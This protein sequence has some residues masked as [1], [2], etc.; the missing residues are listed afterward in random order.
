MLREPNLNKCLAVIFI[1]TSLIIS[2]TFT[3]EPI[4]ASPHTI[5]VPDNYPTITDAIGNATDGTTIYVRQGT[6]Q[7]HTIEI[8]KTLTLIGE[9]PNTTIINNIDVTSWDG[10]SPFFPPPKIAIIIN[11]DNVNISGFTITCKY[12]SWPSIE[13]NANKTQITGNIMNQTDVININGNNNTFAQNTIIGKGNGY[14]TCTGSNNIITDNTITGR[15]SGNINIKGSSNIIYNNTIT[16]CNGYGSIDIAGNKNTVAKNNLTNSGHLGISGSNNIV[17]ANT[18]NSNLALVGSNNTFYANYAQGIIIGSTNADATNN[19]LYL[20]NFNFLDEA[21]PVGDKT[22]RVMSAVN[23]PIFLDNGTVGNYWSDY[24]G[25]NKN[26]DG[27]GDIPYVIYTK[28][29]HNYHW[30]ADFDIADLILTDHYPLMTPVNISSVTVELPEWANITSS[31]PP[32]PTPTSASSPSAST[33][34]TPNPTTPTPQPQTPTPTHPPSTPPSTTQQPTPSNSASPTG[35]N[36]PVQTNIFWAGA[37]IV[38]VTVTA[39]AAAVLLK[40]RQ[41]HSRAKVAE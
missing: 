11:V 6:Y 3:V 30:T 29:P 32:F 41:Q 8:N 10:I 19:T 33:P 16:N 23:G 13:V 27:I 20:N 38:A 28:D 12:G 24:N 18:I 15:A 1:L 21:L 37:T 40:R 17:Y 9:K 22:F 5:T 25:T 31:T 34:K 26:G 7:E 35:N 39:V 36:S 4:K 2:L 14:L